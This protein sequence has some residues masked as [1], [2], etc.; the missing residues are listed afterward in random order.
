MMVHFP[1]Y[2]T[3]WIAISRHHPCFRLAPSCCV[4]LFNESLRVF[5]RKASFRSIAIRFKQS[6]SLIITTHNFSYLFTLW[7]NKKVLF[8]VSRSLSLILL[9]W[10]TDAKEEKWET[11]HLSSIFSSER[12]NLHGTKKVQANQMETSPLIRVRTLDEI[13]F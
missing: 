1:Y 11:K 10:A 12:K 5:H 13:T 8:I 3:H 2:N 4:F 7:L 6:T 9:E